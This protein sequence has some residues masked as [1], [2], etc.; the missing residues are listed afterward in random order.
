LA[1]IGFTLRRLTERD[2]LSGLAGAYAHAALIS[3]GPWLFTIFALTGVNVFLAN[4]VPQDAVETFRIVIVYNFGFSLVVAGPV[5][6]VATRY[7][8]D[9]IYSKDVSEAPGM[10]LGALTLQFAIQGAFGVPYYLF[11]VDM[12]LATRLLS[13]ANFFAVGGIWVVA[14]FLSAIKS[15]RTITAT[16]GIGMA[17]AFLFAV[18]FANAVGAAGILAGFTI[19][20][21]AIFFSLV[22]RV[23]AEYPYRVKTPFGFLKY[24]GRYW[25][26]ALAGGF[27]NAAIWIDKWV[28]WFAPERRVIAGAM[29]SYPTYDSA[30]FLAYLSILPG[31]AIFLISIETRFFERYLRFYRD[32]QGHGSWSTIERNHRSIIDVL[33]ESL[34]NVTVLQTVV[35]LLMVLLAASI[36]EVTR[37]DFAQIGIF[38]FGCL[39]ALFHALTLFCGIVLSYFDLRKHL[40]V[41]YGVFLATTGLFAWISR[42]AGFAW[43]G[44]G[45]FLAALVTFLVA[46]L[47][48]ARA[49]GRLPYLT[50]VANNQGLR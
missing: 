3:S 49:V 34:R 19:G 4:F 23:L 38:R 42:E 22:A 10:M 48:A 7:L 27:Y 13:I 47:L 5:T 39:G 16:F 30:M 44:Y 20:L 2:D 6:M 1:G 36:L 21:L 26:L 33:V 40:M 9:L 31:L 45:Y 46:Y 29:I 8:A 28:M 50:F 43:Y 32:I 17:L 24:F 35:C 37:S 12:D 18:A 15:Y 11:V 41:V 14:I 25:E